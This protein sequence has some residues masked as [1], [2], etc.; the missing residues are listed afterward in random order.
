MDMPQQ[1]YRQSLQN[2]NVGLYGT[3]NLHLHNS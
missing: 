1:S 3:L 2:R